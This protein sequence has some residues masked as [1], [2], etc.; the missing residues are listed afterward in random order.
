MLTNTPKSDLI[1]RDT[2]DHITQVNHTPSKTRQ[3]K[4]TTNPHEE[5]IDHHTTSKNRILHHKITITTPLIEGLTLQPTNHPHKEEIHMT[6]PQDHKE[7]D[8]PI[9]TM[10]KPNIRNHPSSSLTKTDINYYP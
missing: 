2:Q 10:N 5:T 1:N 6:P 3:K 9:K 7:I 8:T 4:D